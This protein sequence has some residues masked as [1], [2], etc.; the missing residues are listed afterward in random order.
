M[1]GYIALHR[2]LLDSE[3]FA[4]PELLHLFI[5]CLLKANHKERFVPVNNGR[6]TTPIKVGRGQFITGRKAMAEALG[7]PPSTARNRLAKLQALEILTQKKDRH[8]TLV[9]ICN[10]DTYQDEKNEGGQAKDKLRTNKGQA[11]DTNNN[12]NNDKNDKKNTPEQ[13]PDPNQPTAKQHN[14]N[15]P[16]AYT[17]EFESIWEAYGR[18]GSKRKAFNAWSRLNQSQKQKATLHVPQYIA[19][20]SEPRFVKHMERYIADELF[21]QYQPQLKSVSIYS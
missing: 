15:H 2:K 4:S 16:K 9:T 11:K 12:D 19:S 8:Y 13:H 17:R 18:R 10:Y 1:E 20:V 3:V 14:P 5:Y 7:I 21:E 6:S